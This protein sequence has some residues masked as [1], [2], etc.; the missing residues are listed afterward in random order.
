MRNWHV[1][2][3]VSPCSEAV[4]TVIRILSTSHADARLVEFRPFRGECPFPPRPSALGFKDG[5][6]VWRGPEHHV[7]QPL[8]AQPDTW[9]VQ[10][11]T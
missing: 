9:I 2:A 5:S 7:E 11:Q 4:C 3:A 1:E 10:G 8:E 6:G